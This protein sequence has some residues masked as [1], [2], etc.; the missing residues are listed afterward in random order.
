MHV[1]T[2]ITFW[3]NVLERDTWLLVSLDDRKL[4]ILLTIPESG[5]QYLRIAGFHLGETRFVGDRQN[6]L[7]VMVE[8]IPETKHAEMIPKIRE[9]LPEDIRELPIVFL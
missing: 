9:A 3:V 4:G 2:P 6:V 1:E 8:Q 7:S 5:K